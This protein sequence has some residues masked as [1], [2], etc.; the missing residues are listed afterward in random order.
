MSHDQKWK[1]LKPIEKTER[2]NVNI[3][4]QIN[5]YYVASTLLAPLHS[6][7]TKHSNYTPYFIN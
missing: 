1:N 2:E 7:V 5:H 6:D 4:T 3:V